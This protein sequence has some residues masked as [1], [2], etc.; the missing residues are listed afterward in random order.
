M[1]H[2]INYTTSTE[3]TDN[4]PVTHYEFEF[5]FRGKEQ[6]L[7]QTAGWKA[8]YKELSKRIRQYKLWRKPRLRPDDVSGYKVY[9]TLETMQEQAR[10]MCAM[11]VQAKRE[12]SRQ[13]VAQREAA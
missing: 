2:I 11:R 8:E 1:Y 9:S 5:G 3:W 7:E 13:M 10:M 12:A 6:Y 4:G